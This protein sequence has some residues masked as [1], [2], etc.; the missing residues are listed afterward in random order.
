MFMVRGRAGEYILS[1]KKDRSQG[2]ACV[3]HSSLSEPSF[4]AKTRLSLFPSLTDVTKSSASPLQS[5][6]SAHAY[7]HTSALNVCLSMLAC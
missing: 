1:M 4:G 5:R 6:I 3:S 2:C 7:N